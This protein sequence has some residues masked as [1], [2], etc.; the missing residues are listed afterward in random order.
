MIRHP[1]AISVVT[2]GRYD[3]SGE[4][5]LGIFALFLRECGI[6]PQ[7]NIHGKPSMNGTAERRNMTLIDIVR[8][9]INHSSLLESLWRETLKTAVYLLNRI[10]SKVVCRIPHVL[11]RLWPIGMAASHL[12]VIL[13]RCRPRII[14]LGFRW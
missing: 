2:Y 5:R 6:V 1:V 14:W 4:Q 11:Y 7:N 3:G 9:M 10:P 13:R 8:S 12:E